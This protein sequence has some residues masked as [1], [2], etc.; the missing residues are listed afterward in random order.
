[1]LQQIVQWLHDRCQVWNE[2]L[3]FQ[4]A[5]QLQFWNWQIIHHIDLSTSY[6]YHGT[7]WQTVL[8]VIG[9]CWEF[10]FR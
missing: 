6:N 4:L 7:V 10:Q 3:Q 1:M 2:L 8:K 9:N 5:R